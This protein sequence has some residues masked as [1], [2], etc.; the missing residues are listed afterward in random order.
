[1]PLPFSN[2]VGFMHQGFSG[3]HRGLKLIH[4]TGHFIG[5]D[6]RYAGQRAL[7]GEKYG[8]FEYDFMA[9][10][11]EI[12]DSGVRVIDPI[13]KK[14][15]VGAVS[16]VLHKA[17]TGLSGPGSEGQTRTFLRGG[18]VGGLFDVT[19]EGRFHPSNPS[20]AQIQEAQQT[21]SSEFTASHTED[22]RRN[23]DQILPHIER[24]QI[25]L[26]R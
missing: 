23:P 20:Y 21:K 17:G 9:A 3:A 4:E 16:S 7:L 22:W 18:G 14:E 10:V 5:F 15:L 1:L 13:H 11:S 6:E 2:S 25:K 24:D 12:N 26:S 19:N 8:G